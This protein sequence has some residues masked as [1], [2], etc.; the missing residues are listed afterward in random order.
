MNRAMVGLALGGLVL[1]A[2][3]G[4]LALRSTDSQDSARTAAVSGKPLVGGP[5]SLIDQTGKRVTDQDFRGKEMLV[6]F[7]F[8]NCP[9]IC[10]AGLQV[11][12]AALDQLGKKADDVVPLF[13]TLDPE[14]DTPEKMGEYIKNFS[15][16]LVGLTGS[17]SEIAA[18]AKAYR[19]FYQKVPDEK[20]PNNYSVD[21]SAFFYLMGKDG[22]FL[23]PIPITND[24]AQLASSIGKA[25]G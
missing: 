9:D 12:A 23:A 13:I 5:F 4:A 18:T 3:F 14:R 25:L 16:R 22:A 20:N 1:G 7:G 21:H 24:P 8:T 15:P 6:F 2:A 11:M 19:V 10:P 17:A